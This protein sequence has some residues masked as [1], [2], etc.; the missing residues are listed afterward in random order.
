[1]LLGVWLAL[2]AP[3]APPGDVDR[4]EEIRLVEELH[5]LAH[6]QAWAGVERVYRQLESRGAPLAYEELTAGAAAAR[7]LGDAAAA[8]DRLVAAARV[9][10]TREVLDSLA[11]I[12][13]GYG[14]VELSTTRRGEV[15]LQPEVLPFDPEQRAAVEAAR[16]EVVQ[17]GHFRGL[18]PQG[19][20]QF[21]DEA[22]TVRPGIA[23]RIEVDPRE[24]REE[25]NSP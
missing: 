12:D 10:A 7:A 22:F 13:T 17:T 20:Y 3:A 14:P 25:R 23:V 4:A 24:R 2:A 8:R 15:L 5:A 11:A 6:R 16:L 1:M 9:D 19:A 21:G 18:L